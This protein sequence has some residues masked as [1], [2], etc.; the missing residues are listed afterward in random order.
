MGTRICGSSSRGVA[1]NA[2]A[3][4]AK[5]GGDEQRGELAGQER[6]GEASGETDA[7]LHLLHRRAVREPRRAR[8]PRA[9]RARDP[10][11]PRLRARPASPAAIQRRRARPSLTTNTP[12]RP[13]RRTSALAGTPRRDVSGVAAAPPGRR[14]RAKRP[15]RRP[16]GRGQVGAHLDPMGGRVARADDRADHG[17]ERGGLTVDLD[18]HKRLRDVARVASAAS[19]VATTSS[20]PAPSISRSTVPGMTTSPTLTGRALTRPAKGARSSAK[21]SASRADATAARAAAARARACSASCGVA[22]PRAEQGQDAREVRL[23]R[24]LPGLGRLHTRAQ[25]RGLRCARRSLPGARPRPRGT[26]GRS[27]SPA[28]ARPGWRAAA[29]GR[30]RAP[31]PLPDPRARPRPSRPHASVFG[32][33]AGEGAMPGVGSLRSPGAPRS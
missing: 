1:R 21:P 12:A 30:S 14:R 13:P 25:A 10:R 9:L 19:T 22:A 26:A 16:G 3:P 11:G 23:R 4:S 8:A 24:R 5:G 31:S 2:S 17:R 32:R 20:P 27:P 6:L 29:R 33:P 28:R 18:L 15:E 7:H